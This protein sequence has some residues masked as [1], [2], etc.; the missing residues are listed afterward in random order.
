MN[1]YN[2][3]WDGSSSLDGKV[4][5]TEASKYPAFYAAAHYQ[6]G[7]T[8][9]GTNIGKWFLPSL[10]Q[11]K[12]TVTR[13]CRDVDVNA[14]TDW[15]PYI[16]YRNLDANFDK[17]FLQAGGVTLYNDWIWTS[18]E[19]SAH[20]GHDCQFNQNEFEL[21]DFGYDKIMSGLNVRPF[22]HF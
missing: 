13:L 21:D 20:D 3:T 22:V 14:K 19:H 12:L 15:T 9:T 7:P 5:G 10:G 11:I 16:Q 8:I 1:G 18:S 6:P 4:R 2:W 17:I